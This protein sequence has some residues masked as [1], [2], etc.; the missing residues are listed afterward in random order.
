MQMHFFSSHQSLNVTLQRPK[1]RLE[2]AVDRGR[3]ISGDLQTIWFSVYL[4]KGMQ[5]LIRLLGS[6]ADVRV[7]CKYAF[8]PPC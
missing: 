4:G 6:A 2:R 7:A 5:I 1:K 3:R 8:S